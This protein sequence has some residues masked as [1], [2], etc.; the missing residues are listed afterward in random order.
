[1]VAGAA[2]YSTSSSRTGVFPSRMWRDT[3]PTGGHVGAFVI[4]VAEAVA[5]GTLCEV[6]EMESP[7][8]PVG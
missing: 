8:S 1:M 5:V 7:F 2:I 4:V 6:V 3:L